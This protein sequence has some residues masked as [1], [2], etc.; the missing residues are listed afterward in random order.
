MNPESTNA[1]WHLPKEMPASLAGV[2]ERAGLSAERFWV[3]WAQPELRK[4]LIA[5]LSLAE[6]A[7]ETADR[8][9]KDILEKAPSFRAAAE[10]AEVARRRFRDGL[11]PKDK[12]DKP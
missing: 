6:P 10:A 3:Y 4:D 8:T 7:I 9:L 12:P 5:R 2:P 11:R 1:D